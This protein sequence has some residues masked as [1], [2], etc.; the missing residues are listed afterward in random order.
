ML[1]KACDAIDIIELNK[2]KEYTLTAT[3]ILESILTNPNLNAQTVKL[4]QFLF[5]KARFHPNLEVKICYSELA[6]SLHRSN[7]SISRYVKTLAQEGYL[8]I[9]ENFSDDGSQKANTLYVRIPSIVVAEVK[10]KK[11]RAINK[12]SFSSKDSKLASTD[13]LT[14]M[15][16]EKPNSRWSTEYTTTSVLHHSHIAAPISINHM[17]AQAANNITQYQSS[18]KMEL[19][20][21]IDGGVDDK[22][23][24][25]KDNIKKDILTNN[26]IVVI[27]HDYRETTER[28]STQDCSLIALDDTAN[29]VLRGTLDNTQDIADQ[30]KI[31][32]LEKEVTLL[33][34]RRASAVGL[35]FERLHNE[36]RKLQQTISTIG[37]LIAQR[38]QARKA[39]IPDRPDTGKPTNHIDPLT[40][41]IKAE[42]ERKLTSTD[43]E[44]VKR[45]VAKF[46]YPD[47]QQKVC[48]EIIYAVR[49]GTLRLSQNG[50][51]LSIPHAISIALKLV[52]ENRWETPAPIKQQEKV[53]FYF[54]RQDSQ[55]HSVHIH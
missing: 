46:T 20:D 26:N 16:F 3:C 2:Q 51:T 52:R 9:D 41:F 25:L 53:D 4:W 34:V 55:L 29:K 6:K 43:I 35:E 45:A 17:T 8:L 27:Q 23:D 36:I 54:K 40:D 37:V 11:D 14:H 5:N 47:A 10:H 7:R 44:R 15:Q 28:G 19:N 12:V 50:K 24:V 48:N 22:I 1:V 49:F 30:E 21:K 18:I 39:I 32:N 38:K 42:G 31:N 13:E 33:H